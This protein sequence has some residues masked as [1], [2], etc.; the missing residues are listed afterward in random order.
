MR[1]WQT[2]CMASFEDSTHWWCFSFKG[3]YLPWNGRV[4]LVLNSQ[5]CWILAL[6]LKESEDPTLMRTLLS[7]ITIKIWAIL[8]CFENILK[9]LKLLI[10]GS[11]IFFPNTYAHDNGKYMPLISRML[12]HPNLI[13]LNLFEIFDRELGANLVKYNN[14]NLHNNN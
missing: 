11:T 9:A 8:G 3:L 10:Q 1:L 14:I 13:S 6:C 7:I 4:S 12:M 5:W 2:P